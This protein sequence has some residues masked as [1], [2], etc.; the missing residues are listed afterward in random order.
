MTNIVHISANAG[1]NLA[2]IINAALAEP[3]VSTV[4]LEPGL[5]LIE[6]PIFVPSNKTLMGSGRNDTIIRADS[7][8]AI[9][10]AQFNAVI[11]SEEHSSG[12][13]LSDFTVDAAKISPAA[14]G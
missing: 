12:I 1:P 10:S 2:A 4:I 8:F 14:C 9:P 7:D 5:F 6:S 13:T 11:M 3:N